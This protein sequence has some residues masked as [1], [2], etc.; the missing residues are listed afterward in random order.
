MSVPLKQVFLESWH[1]TFFL[2]NIYFVSFTIDAWTSKFCTY[3][4]GIAIHFI[5]TF[6]EIISISTYVP[7]HGK[8]AGK[9]NGNIFLETAIINFNHEVKMLDNTGSNTNF[10]NP[11]T[12]TTE[13]HNVK[14]SNTNSLSESKDGG[15]SDNK[16]IPDNM[17]INSAL[18]I[19]RSEQLQRK[20]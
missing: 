11:Y 4:Y 7:S 14:A 18:G 17:K 19:G 2:Q 9:D 16:T 1:Y 13:N 12:L 10:I 15:N 8:H 20:F 5:D 6:L 3:I